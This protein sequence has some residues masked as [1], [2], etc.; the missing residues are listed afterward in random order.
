MYIVTGCSS[1]LG[2]E[3]TKQLLNKKCEVVGLSRSLGKAILFN[4]VDNFD[5]IKC[6]LMEETDFTFLDHMLDHKDVRIIINAAQ[7]AFEEEKSLD[8]GELKSMFG[9]NYFSAVTLIDKFKEKG[10][11]RVLFVNSVSGKIPQ[12][13]QFQ[14]SASKHALQ[15]Y[16]ETLAK[17]SK[18]KDFDVM[19]INPGGIN[20]ELWEKVDMLGQDITDGFIDPGE[21]ARLICNLLELSQNTY[22]KSAIILPEHDV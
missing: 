9:V 2:F 21:L 17:Y 7:F 22:L 12:A 13:A 18:G 15:S 14:Y 10:L 5:F 3:I 6:D 1:G 4:E 16:S 20:S 8:I 19:S 11:K